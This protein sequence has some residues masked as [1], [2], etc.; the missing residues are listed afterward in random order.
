MSNRNTPFS[1]QL[2]FLSKGC[3]D[4]E[5]TEALSDLVKAVR[6]TGKSGELTLKLKVSMLNKRDENAVKITPTVKAKAPELA[7]YET[8][9]FSTG[10]GDLIREDPNQR[11]LPLEE[12]PARSRAEP[13]PIGAR[14]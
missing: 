11:K 1:Q 6:E 14:Q 9:M 2:A 13:Q 12:V 4:D 5:L 7:P 10:D 8:V 3:L